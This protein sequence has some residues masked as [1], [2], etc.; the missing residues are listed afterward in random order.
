MKI[1]ANNKKAY[2]DY[3]L[4]SKFEAGIVLIGS[5]VKSVKDGGVS[6]KES[7]IKIDN[8]ELFLKN[9]YI[10]PYDK[11]SAY[12]PDSKRNRKLLLH[13]NQ[14]NKLE[15][16]LNQKGMTIVPLKI[17]EKNGLIK[18]EIAVA[19]GKKNFDKRKAIAERSAKKEVARYVK[20]TIGGR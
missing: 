20:K 8:N 4:L 18:I 7:F 1:I 16:E 2:H 6:I 9:A 15:K 3:F 13:K 12:L 5:E 19:K 10:K 17:Y 11:A 14:I